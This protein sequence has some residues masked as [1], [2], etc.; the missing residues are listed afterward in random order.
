MKVLYFAISEMEDAAEDMSLTRTSEIIGSSSYMSPEQ[1]RSSKGV[2][3]TDIW[4]LGVI[5]FEPL[6]KKLPFQAL[7]VTELVAVVLT[8]PV[9]DLGADRPDVPQALTDAIHRCLAK[10]RLLCDARPDVDR[11]RRAHRDWRRRERHLLGQ[12]HRRSHL[13]DRE[14]V[15]PRLRPPA[16]GAG[17]DRR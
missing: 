12:L 17:R 8:E 10:K 3:R 7:T 9:P 5:L 2:E 6:T 15:R 4:A 13:E 16:L 14:A 11:Q 1:L